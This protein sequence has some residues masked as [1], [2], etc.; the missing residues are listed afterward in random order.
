ML[1]SPSKPAFMIFYPFP[2]FIAVSR[3]RSGRV[4]VVV[5]VMMTNECGR[6][7]GGWKKKKKDWPS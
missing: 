7:G 3:D 6:H 4:A 5:V 2:R 1:R